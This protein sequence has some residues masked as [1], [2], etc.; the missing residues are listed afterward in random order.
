MAATTPSS[1]ISY[2]T[3]AIAAGGLLASGCLAYAIY[4]D[5]RRRSDPEFRK[6]LRRQQKKVS[7]QNEASAKDAERHQKERIRTAVD[8]AIAEGFPTDAEETEAYF[9]QQVAQ[10]EGMCSDGSDPVEAALYFYKA[11]KVYPQPRELIQIYDKT[12]PKVSYP[13][14]LRCEI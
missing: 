7:R 10:G 1:S 11:L 4:F 12:V 6:S 2:S 13:E 9:M 3:I 8:E 14:A 5:H